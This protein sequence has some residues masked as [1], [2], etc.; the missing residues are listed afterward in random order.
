ML[1]IVDF[2]GTIAPTDTVDALLER[3]AGPAWQDLEREWVNGNINS[4]QCMAGQIAL[5]RGEHEVLKEF[6][7]NVQIDPSFPA[8]V[9]YASGL[10]DVVVVS[11]GLDYPIKHALAN[12]GVDVPVIA[13]ALRFCDTGLALSFPYGDAACKV[14]SG[15]CKCAAALA[16]NGP[17]VLIGDGRSDQCVARI[18]DV[19]FAKSKLRSICE[20]EGIP[21]IPFETFADVL[22]TL[23]RWDD[24]EQERACPVAA[25]P[26]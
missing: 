16:G 14:G 17:L 20:T 22:A 23:R 19:V 8:F 13:N 9:E 11:D 12:A 10:G 3:F 24:E 1:F 25:S 15:V 18:C 26:M 4:Q 2:D 7:E 5:V 21:H 6:L